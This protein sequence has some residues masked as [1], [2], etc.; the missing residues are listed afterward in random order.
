MAAELWEY[1]ARL[2]RR[3]N[4]DPVDYAWQ[5][6]YATFNNNPMLYYD[7]NGLEG[8][9]KGSKG[10]DPKKVGKVGSFLRD[11]LHNVTHPFSQ[12]NS[13]GNTYFKHPRD[14]DFSGWPSKVVNWIGRLF[15]QLHDRILVEKWVGDDRHWI[16][17]I[18][19]VIGN[20]YYFAALGG[21]SFCGER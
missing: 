14:H 20:H 8:E 2:G 10:D 13:W 21:N 16:E 4:I 6:S 12:H 18:G 17:L 5:S 9:A 15:G 19:D 1:D 11:L 3:W 7:P